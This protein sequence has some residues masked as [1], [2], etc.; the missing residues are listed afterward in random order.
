MTRF[1]FL[2]SLLSLSVLA[3]G[4]ASQSEQDT[5]TLQGHWVPVLFPSEKGM[6]RPEWISFNGN[7]FSIK[8]AQ[9]DTPRT[10]TYTLTPEAEPAQIVIHDSDKKQ[11]NNLS[12]IYRIEGD[13]LHLCFNQHK[14]PDFPKEFKTIKIGDKLKVVYFTF[15]RAPATS[16][17]DT[18]A[19]SLGTGVPR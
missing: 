16:R 5:A 4:C 12:G 9:R 13:T 19:P 10:T 1:L 6:K 17:W 7:Q 18:G 2:A 14:V 15:R 3:S 8:H 11:G